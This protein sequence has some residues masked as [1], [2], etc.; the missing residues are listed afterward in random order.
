MNYEKKI[1]KISKLIT[2]RGDFAP[3]T[4]EVTKADGV[5]SF[6]NGIFEITSRFEHHPTGVIKR[7]DTVKNVSDRDISISSA[8]SKFV[9][10]GGDYEVYTQYSEWCGESK[11]RWQ[12]LVTEV[13]AQNDD[14]RAN[15]GAAPFVAVYNLQNGRGIA[16]HILC[17]GVWRYR[18]RK[19]FSQTGQHKTVTVELGLDDKLFDYILSTGAS[20]ELPSI[21]YYEF[22]NKTDTPACH[23]S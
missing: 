2:I 7:C 22:R 4:G 8:L 17:D 23:Y 3:L 14:V 9:L 16:F 20:L 13:C 18:V 5:V 10:N 12:P 6:N 11:G 19:H 21:V 15:A 1:N